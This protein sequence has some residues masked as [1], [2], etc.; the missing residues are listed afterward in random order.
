MEQ[1]RLDK[2]IE[3]VRLNRRTSLNLRNLLVTPLPESIGNLVDLT[4]LDLA[5]NQLTS[6]PDSIGNLI[7]LTHLDL[8]C[9]PNANAILTN[10]DWQVN[11]LA[12][13]PDS[14]GNL[15]SLTHLNLEGN[16]LTS[17]PGSIGNLVNL[18]SLNLEVNQ[19]TSLPGSIG[20][21]V[22][23]T[24][25]NL[26]RNQL[27]SLPESIGSLVNLTSL[28]LE[29]NQ[30]TSLPE[31]IGNLVSLTSLNLGGQ[32]TSLLKNIGDLVNVRFSGHKMLRRYWTDSSEWKSEWLLEES[33]AKIRHDLIAKIGYEKICH[34][35]NAVTVNT[36]REY[37]LLKIDGLGRVYNLKREPIERVPMVLLK[38]TCP[39]T[40]HIHILRVPP[41]MTS[42]EEAITW[43]NHGI[44]PDT[45][46]VQT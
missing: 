16:Q 46:A 33:N 43:V 34:E 21:L 13:L 11:L 6:L 9:H 29:R 2:I 31:S 37:T 40:A 35:L 36:W 12:N 8:G 44:H 27:T 14:I 42:A 4:H 22:N 23:L 41:E 28:N 7:N 5:E 26:E 32:S 45:F 18:T 17:L 19:L 20:N 25:L 3:Q 30:L 15:T 10:M 38:M 39:S 24:S 1:A